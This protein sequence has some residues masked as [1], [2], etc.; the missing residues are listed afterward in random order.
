MTSAKKAL[1]CL[2]SGLNVIFC[3]GEKLNERQSG[4]T[5]SVLFRQLSALSSVIK[6]WSNVVIAYEPVWAIG[7]YIL[8]LR[9]R[10]CCNSR[11]SSR[12]PIK[13]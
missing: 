2:K 12:D 5:N 13:H 4:Q 10:G 3:I 1:I 6:D 8:M 11:T 7:L 9:Y